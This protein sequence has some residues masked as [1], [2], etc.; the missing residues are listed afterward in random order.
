[1]VKRQF[2][3]ADDSEVLVGR[4][5]L[6]VWVIKYALRGRLDSGAGSP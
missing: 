3:A 1:M 6:S 4:Q 2:G 5:A